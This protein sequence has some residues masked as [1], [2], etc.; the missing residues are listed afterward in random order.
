MDRAR[1]DLHRESRNRYS[2]VTRGLSA[3]NSG[4][5]M[6][7]RTHRGGPPR[8]ENETYF[9]AP[10]GSFLLD[11]GIICAI[12]LLVWVQW[13]VAA[14][15]EEAKDGGK[16]FYVLC[17]VMGLPVG[18]SAMGDVED[19]EALIRREGADQG[20]DPTEEL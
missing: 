11:F 16:G 10:T 7:D 5:T 2:S 4:F 20:T 19:E 14:M 12:V 3:S 17:H 1:Q 18:A 8:G 9:Y 6:F 13:T 15:R